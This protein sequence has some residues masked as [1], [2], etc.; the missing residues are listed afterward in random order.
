MATTL[1]ATERKILAAA[2]FKTSPSGSLEAVFASFN[3]VDHDSDVTLPGAFEDGKEVPIGSWGHKS[4]ELPIGRGTIVTTAREA[5][6]KG[7]LFLDT[8]AGRDAYETLKGLGELGEWSYVFQVKRS[9]AGDFDGKRVRFLDELEVF[10]VDPV[11]KGAGIN[12]R[13]VA[14]K[15]AG[16][17]AKDGDIDVA[18]LRRLEEAN[19]IRLAEH[20]FKDI[21]DQQPKDHYVLDAGAV[22]PLTRK[23]ALAAVRK[24]SSTLGIAESSIEW[25]GAAAGAKA[26]WGWAIP[27]AKTIHLNASLAPEAAYQVAAHEVAHVAGFDE[28]MANE[29]ERFVMQLA[30]EDWRGIYG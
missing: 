25:F 30:R 14:V 8:T 23:A 22:H 6:I 4:S 13:T 3:V 5:R 9:H 1:P 7:R 18:T 19:L 28:P 29:F 17:S 2:E 21:L 24:A 20:R 12:T 26:R 15:C 10:S 16:C 27:H 11:L